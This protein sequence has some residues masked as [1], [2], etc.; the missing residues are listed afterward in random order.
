MSDAGAWS[1]QAWMDGHGRAAYA[2]YSATMGDRT[3]DDRP[4]PAWSRLTGTQRA[5][6]TMAALAAITRHTDK[7]R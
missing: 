2:A 6:W 3:P 1:T 4:M 7:E 5:A